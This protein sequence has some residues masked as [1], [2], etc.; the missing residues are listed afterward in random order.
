MC[1][2]V[3]SLGQF[4]VVDYRTNTLVP[5]QWGVSGDGGEMAMTAV[6]DGQVRWSNKSGRNACAYEI[7]KGVS[8]VY[9]T[10]VSP[11]NPCDCRGWHGDVIKPKPLK[12]GSLLLENT[13]I[14]GEN[15]FVRLVVGGGMLENWNRG[16]THWYAYFRESVDG[17]WH[18]LVNNGIMWT[19]DV[20]LSDS[21][22][23]S[24]MGQMFFY[25][26]LREFVFK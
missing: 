1:G 16:R 20:R 26:A 3:S 25:G 22:V 8:N 14:R 5:V 21:C 17:T 24:S 19:V 13:T 18:F 6:L 9:E 15:R 7:F 23:M 2:S 11:C 12:D 4:V 10:G